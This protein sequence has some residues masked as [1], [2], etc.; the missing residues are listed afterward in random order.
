MPVADLV[1]GKAMVAL[2]YDGQPLASGAWRS[3]A[4][5]RAASLFLEIGEVGERA[6]IHR[7]RRSRASGS[8]AA[9]TSMAIPGG[10]SASPV[11]EPKLRWQQ[12]RIV[13]ITP[14]SPRIKSFIFACRAIRLPRRPA[15]RRAADR[16]GRLPGR[17]LLLDRL[18]AGRP[19]V[20]A[21]DRAPRGRR[22]LA[23]LPRGRRR[24][25]TRSSSAV[26]SAGTS[27]GRSRTA[28]RSCCSAAARVVPW[29]PMLRHRAGE[30]DTADGAPLFRPHL[31]RADLPRRAA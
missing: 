21:R 16:A 11:T 23:V 3:G 2:K 17:A 25:A 27:S 4:P 7:E 15:C 30:V 26:R 6:A 14:L 29:S 8:F 1:G 5:S 20:R 9:I 28:A 19:Y 24:S 10:S 31:G 18:R 22:G 12:A 13:A